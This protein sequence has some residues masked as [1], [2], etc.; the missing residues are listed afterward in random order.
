MEAIQGHHSLFGGRLFA[1]FLRLLGLADRP[2][3]QARLFFSLL[4]L[5][6]FTSSLPSCGASSGWRS[7]GF[8]LRYDLKDGLL[9]LLG[10]SIGLLRGGLGSL[11]S[12]L[13]SLLNGL[14]GKLGW[15]TH[16]LIDELIGRAVLLHISHLLSRRLLLSRCDSL[17][18]DLLVGDLGLLSHREF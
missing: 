8:R 3:S 1:L 18:Q 6:R 5:G 2:G 10:F 13:R 4:R 16:G 12:I 9:L 15:L 14:F 11:S 17:S 7:S